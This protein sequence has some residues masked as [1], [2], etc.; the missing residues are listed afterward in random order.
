M[1]TILQGDA[2]TMLKTLPSESIHC[3]VTSPPYWGLRDYKVDGQLGLEPIPQEYIA[4]MLEVF[5]EVKRV[6]RSDG[7]LWLNMG[8][9]YVSG[10]RSTYRSGVSDN[11]GHLIQNDMPRPKTPPGLKPKDLL[12]MPWMLA[13][14]L[15]DDGW[16][17]RSEIIW[18][19]TNPMPESVTDRP[20]KAHEQIFLL[21]K[22]AKYFYDQE[23]VREKFQTDP[24]ENYPERA[25]ITGRGKQDYPGQ[26]QDK[27]GGYPPSGNGRNL[28]SVWT[29]ATQP[30]P[31]AHFATFPEELAK[32]CILA[33]TSARGCCPKCGGPWIREIKKES[34]P[35]EM[36][37]KTSNPCDEFVNSARK[38]G[39]RYGSGQKADNWRKEHPSTTLGFRPSCSCALDPIPCAVL[40]PF[41]GSG[42]TGAVALKLGRKAV[43]IELKEEYCQMIKKRC[44]VNMG[45]S[46]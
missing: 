31:E 35:I 40:D 3:C 19:K 36:L 6:L 12:G 23:A 9:C 10:D 39:V 21:S 11:K 4:K 7:T 14:A 32:R 34:I 8:D 30:F 45:L 15:R 44:K 29:F 25:R 41:A 5:Q 17:L 28:R 37:T 24:K 16:W 18:A 1:L 42:T 2:F 46:L 20:T 27:S 13:F 22:S 38:N 33:G 43:L 26:N